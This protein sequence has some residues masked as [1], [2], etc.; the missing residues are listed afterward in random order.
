MTNKYLE[1]IAL[2]A[3]KARDMA[4]AVGVIP[5]PRSSW[6][7]ALRNLRD[8][9]GNP[10]QGRQLSEGRTRL[11]DLSNNAYNKT[12][13]LDR[14]GGSRHIEYAGNVDSNGKLSSIVTGGKGNI[15]GELALHR[16]LHTHPP[17]LS[18]DYL[19]GKGKGF[20]RMRNLKGDIQYTHRHAGPSGSDRPNVYNSK[21]PILQSQV[22]H[23]SDILTDAISKIRE[24]TPDNPKYNSLADTIDKLKGKQDRLQDAYNGHGLLAD[25][26]SFATYAPTRVNQISSPSVN[27]VSANKISNNGLRT[28]Y[29]DHSPRKTKIGT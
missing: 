9:R 23:S 10:L 12:K 6:K 26:K 29:F 15:P 14:D 11:G 2:N 28:V 22:T 20:Y 1:K 25:V 21:V 13:A 27:T 18:T 8:T 7:Y 4:K 3:Q 19:K 5:D 24:L 16:S 17:L